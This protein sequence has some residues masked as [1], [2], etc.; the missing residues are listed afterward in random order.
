M[1]CDY[2]IK[3]S[4]HFLKNLVR[5]EESKIYTVAQQNSLAPESFDFPDLTAAL[6]WAKQTGSIIHSTNSFTLALADGDHIWTQ[7][8]ILKQGVSDLFNNDAGSFFS[9]SVFNIVG[10]SST[11]PNP[12]TI[13]FDNN[14]KD[15]E[16]LNSVVL[17]SGIR[18]KMIGTNPNILVKIVADKSNIRYENN[19]YDDIA[20]AS[21]NNSY[22]VLSGSVLFRNNNNT[23]KELFEAENRSLI[24]CDNADLTGGDY[25]VIAKNNSNILMRT[26]TND[27]VLVY[28]PTMNTKSKDMS[29]I[30]D[31]TV[32]V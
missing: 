17:F 26:S 9:G 10:G 28:T 15:V 11:G 13:K 7:T 20:I 22:C 27:G 12:V 23:H 3:D 32:V 5:R 30:Y 24:V 25:T 2:N 6:E 14:V 29:V 4:V 1:T 21:R 19:I 18:L 8:D 31:G 16:F